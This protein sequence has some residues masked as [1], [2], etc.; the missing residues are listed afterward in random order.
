MQKGIG[1]LLVVLLFISG[2]LQSA[3]AQ[4]GG[5]PPEPARAWIGDWGEQIL[6]SPGIPEGAPLDTARGV[7]D[8]RTQNGVISRVSRGDAP[9][10]FAFVKRG[11]TIQD[12]HALPT[13]S[14]SGRW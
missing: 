4:G 10:C 6:L 2:R 12:R 11:V 14:L 7:F 1:L 8:Q 3:Q 5:C 9:I 13:L